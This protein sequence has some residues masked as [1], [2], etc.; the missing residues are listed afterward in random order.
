LKKEIL[1]LILLF[2]LLVYSYSQAQHSNKLEPYV[3]T[4]KEKGNKPVH[5]VLD[6]L[7][8][9]NLILF[10]DALHTAVEP[11]EFYQELIKN[12]DFQKKV[13]FIFLEAVP[14]NQQP[15][16]DAYF[17]SEKD[18][19][20][21]LYP[22]FQNDFSGMGWRY[23]TYFDLLQTIWK[24]N[25]ELSDKNK[26]EVIAVNAPTYWSEVNT[27]KDVELFR[28]SL[29][30]NDY[31][32]Y[33]IILSHLDNFESG[34]KGIFLTNTRHA[35]KQIKNRNDKYYWNCGTFFRMHNPDETYSIHFHNIN[36]FFKAVKKVDPN[37]PKTTE[38]LENVKV[39]WV[40]MEKGLWDSAFEEYGNKPVAFDLKDT[41]YGEAEYIGNHMLN[42]AS[43]QTM[44]DA[45]DAL[46]FLAPVN[47]LRQTAMVD[48]IYTTEFKKELERRIYFLYTEEQINNILNS[49]D[50]KSVKEF[51]F[52]YFQSESEKS[53]PLFN[54][55]GPID[56]WKKE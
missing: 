24:T 17:E 28:L 56:E 53:Q 44:Y 15:A 12:I 55:V 50:L 38:G 39:E 40:R 11:F 14:V 42:V 37:I 18:D 9:Y 33:K 31:T 5:F 10:D 41:P 20:S 8:N 43:D 52:A 13:R 19:I 46:I 4:L 51:I 45:Y 30:G 2:I 25:K 54:K 7:E 27:Q 32:M 26:Y 6:K 16:I 36:L 49:Y 47:E 29:A 21:L 35:Y 34:E 1:S 48:F 3:K 23:K 22:A